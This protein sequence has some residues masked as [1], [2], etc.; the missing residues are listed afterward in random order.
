MIWIYDLE[1]Y[2]NFFSATF[3]NVKTKEVR[4]FVIHSTRNDIDE[5]HTFINDSNKWLVGYNSFN[6]DNQI[7]NLI[8]TKHFDL[9]MGS[10]EKAC[11]DIYLLARM[12]VENN[13]IDY[14]YN[15][16]FHSIDLMK[17]G[18]YRKSLKLIGVSLKWPKL[19]DLPIP[20]EEEIQEDQ[21]DFI[22]EYNLNDVS[23]TERLFYHLEDNIKLRF[24]I[25]KRYNVNVYSESDSGIAN[26]LL[27]R[28][29][30]ETSGLA[31]RDFKKLRTPRKF[32]RFEW[33]VFDDIHFKTEQLET[34][35][36]EVKNHVYYESHPFFKK[37]IT[38]DEVKYQM[39]VGGLHSVDQSALFEE[40]KDTFIIDADMNKPVSG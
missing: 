35:L 37:T 30:S 32:I 7:L 9:S 10:A 8:H 25:A 14:R 34:L 38:F 2:S 5:L 11:W 21:I 13:F 40:T 28:F 15:L 39:G 3:K 33:V 22:L 18:F 1:T 36:E 29:Y 23:I 17:V 26:R 12:I 24:D 31:V 20:W 27:E 6:F 19:Q 16:P 4:V